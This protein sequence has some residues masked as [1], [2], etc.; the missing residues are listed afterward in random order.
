MTEA[1]FHVPPARRRRPRLGYLMAVSAATLWAAN[2]T[3]SKIVLVD[4]L[5]S[6]E[7]AQ[8][9]STGAFLL[10]GLGLLVF[11]RRSLRVTRRELPWLVLFGVGGLAFVQLFYFLAIRRLDI[12]VALLIEYL[13]PLLVALFARFVW[14][15]HVRRRVWAALGL[16]LAGLALIV[17]LAHG[18][19]LDG[20]GVGAALAGAVTYAAY[21]L[22]ADRSD[23]DTVSLLCYGF[24]FASVFWAIVL[25]WWRFPF[26]VF[27]DDVSLLG[28][29][30]GSSLPGGVLVLLIVVLGTILPFVLLVGAL[31][32]LPATRVAIAAMAEPVVAT[33]V[34]WA[35]LGESLGPAELAGG[36][37]VL[38]AILLAQTAR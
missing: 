7:L 13:A 6:M 32:H 35:W 18:V 26:H 27:T 30:E 20:A 25:P 10:L 4:G 28:R 15:E 21:L 24:G 19:T 37:V 14:K 17:D 31:S 16:A 11:A 9:R 34:A 29:L 36:G 12:G 1:P 38:V 22:L 2:G 3:V 33:V 8:V 23:R 5:T